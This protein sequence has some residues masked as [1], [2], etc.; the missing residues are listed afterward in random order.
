M[1]FLDARLPPRFWSKAIPEPNS[2][3]WIWIAATWGR[4]GEYGHYRESSSHITAFVAAG[5]VIPDGFVLDHK[6]RNTLCCNPAHLEA[7]TNAVNVQR[8]ASGDLV[9]HCPNGHEYT[10]ENTIRSPRRKCR[11]CHN[12]RMRERMRSSRLSDRSFTP[13]E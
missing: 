13:P 12:D 6:C 8:G 5:N 2:G 4:S 11:T 9:T 10:E 7:V 1:Q 3:C